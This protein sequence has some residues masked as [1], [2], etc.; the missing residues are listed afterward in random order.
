MWPAF[1]VYTIRCVINLSLRYKKNFADDSVFAFCSRKI[2]RR[3]QMPWGP[4]FKL[5]APCRLAFP[6]D[7]SGLGYAFAVERDI[8]PFTF[9]IFFHP[10]AHEGP[11]D[12]DQNEGN[13]TAIGDGHA[14]TIKLWYDLRYI[15]F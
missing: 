5:R 11:H 12:L 2:A 14:H 4:E 6:N 10:Q 15:T 8:Q 3:T 13:D 7:E 1:V 9:V